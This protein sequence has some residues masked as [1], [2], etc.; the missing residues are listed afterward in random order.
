MISRISRRPYLDEP[1]PLHY[2]DKILPFLH[3]SYLALGIFNGLLFSFMTLSLYR[4]ISDDI[5]E[6]QKLRNLETLVVISSERNEDG[7]SLTLMR[8]DSTFYTLYHD[9]YLEVPVSNKLNLRLTKDGPFRLRYP[10]EDNFDRL[11]IRASGQSRKLEI[12]DL[13]GNVRNVL[14]QYMERC[15]E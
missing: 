13:S 2:L 12:E 11:E 1:E 10:R 14:N 6:K 7:S 15:F 4:T 5:W 8:P 9:N 3:P